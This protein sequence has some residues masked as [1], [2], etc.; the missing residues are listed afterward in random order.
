MRLYTFLNSPNP[1]KIRLALAELNLEYESKEVV[2]FK[3]EHRSEWFTKI[4]PHQKVPV[5][6]DGDLVLR[7]S[8]AI[9]AYLGDRYGQALWPQDAGQRALALQWLFFE[10]F[11]I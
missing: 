6:E 1:L 9:L 2:L 3:G 4:N 7:E 11:R 5:L 8:N 10:S